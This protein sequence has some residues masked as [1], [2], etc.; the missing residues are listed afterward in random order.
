[1]FGCSVGGP[2]DHGLRDTNTKPELLFCGCDCHDNPV[3][4]TGFHIC[5][6]EV[7]TPRNDQTPRP[8]LTKAESVIGD[9]K[10]FTMP[11]IRQPF[12]KLIAEDLVNADPGSK[13][14]FKGLARHMLEV[15]AAVQVKEPP[16]TFGHTKLLSR[17]EAE[18]LSTP[19]LLAYRSSLYKYPE[20]PSYDEQFS[21]GKDYGLYKSHP[22]WKNAMEV[23]KSVLATRE[24]V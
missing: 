20:G 3:V 12:P 17:E 1:M 15:S 4:C 11:V 10:T 24:N 8:P 5:C 7:N 13:E 21:G 16:R 9:F 14:L 2:H 6:H 22:A 18:K 19:R 23:V